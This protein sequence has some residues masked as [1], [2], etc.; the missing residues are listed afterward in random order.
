MSLDKI[1]GPPPALYTA[2]IGGPIPDCLISINGATPIAGNEERLRKASPLLAS[3]LA[4]E[5]FKARNFSET[6]LL[7]L[8]LTSANA[9]LAFNKIMAYL[10]TG[11]FELDGC[12]RDQILSVADECQIHA[13]Q[14]RF[15]ES[16]P[17]PQPKLAP[18]MASMSLPPH[19]P[20]PV[21]IFSPV[22]NP[23]LLLNLQNLQSQLQA[24]NFFQM[25]M[26][27]LH[28]VS[29]NHEPIDVTPK[30]RRAQADVRELKK[31][32][33]LDSNE[34]PFDNLGDVIIPSTD[35]EGWC[36]NKKYI[37]KTEAGFMCIVCKKIYGRY[38]SVSYH[39]TIYHRNPPIKCDLPGC[40]FTTREARYI[41]FHK[42]YRHGI[43]LP[44]SID[45]G[46]RRC[47]HCRHVSKS[48]AMLEKH[49]RR[50]QIVKSEKEDDPMD[51]SSSEL[52]VVDDETARQRALSMSMDISEA[53]SD[54]ALTKPRAFTL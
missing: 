10:S 22:P 41:H 17:A 5:T 29:Q 28:P 35:K 46:S 47:P 18:Q 15:R 39:V 31:A 20:S 30:K 37:E 3:L 9:E 49:I 12:T 50:H 7:Q 42:Y 13:L 1:L 40:Q 43:A 25:F 53:P 21:P 19:L 32:H 36:R 11:N 24:A 34:E 44:Q 52:L 54:D 45:Q 4:D 16:L 2:L 38:N 33:S 26:S 14:E 8:Y 23:F 27:Q 6:R 48:P 51:P